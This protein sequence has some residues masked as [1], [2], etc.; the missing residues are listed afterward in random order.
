[1]PIFRN[2]DADRLGLPKGRLPRW[3]GPPGQQRYWPAVPRG[4]ELLTN[5]E[6]ASEAAEQAVW[7][8]G[9]AQRR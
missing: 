5:E 3:L 7:P 6:G 4:Q 2:A 9:M 8:R 1:M